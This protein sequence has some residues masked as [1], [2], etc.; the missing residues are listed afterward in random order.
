MLRVEIIYSSVILR[1]T[2]TKQVYNI[3]FPS[4][5]SELGENKERKGAGERKRE[6][7]QAGRKGAKNYY[8]TKR[9]AKLHNLPKIPLQA[10]VKSR[11]ESP[12]AQT[13]AFFP[14]SFDKGLDF[15]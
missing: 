11:K 12:G 4:L 13:Q 14:F 10:R 3:L 8:F 1:V 15:C 9:K 7:R 5:K 2:V 6:E